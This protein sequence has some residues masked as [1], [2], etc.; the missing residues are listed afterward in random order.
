MIGFSCKIDII[1]KVY[2]QYLAIL[3]VDFKIGIIKNI[4]HVLGFIKV[5]IIP[6]LHVGDV[7]VL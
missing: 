4:G 2:E 3:L 5:H 6:T 1:I 7:F